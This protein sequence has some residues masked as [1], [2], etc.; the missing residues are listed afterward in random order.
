MEGVLKLNFDRSSKC[1][2]GPK[3]FDCIVRNSISNVKVLCGPFEI[4]NSIKA[5]AM[6]L[7][8][9]LRELRSTGAQGYIMEGDLAI[10]IGWGIRKGDGPWT[11]AHI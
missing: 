5:Q 7:L 9:S 3:G 4:S 2:P 6:A 10:V 1:S 11:L 8:M